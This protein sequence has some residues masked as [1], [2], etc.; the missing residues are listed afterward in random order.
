M[1]MSDP[2]PERV[3]YVLRIRLPRDRSFIFARAI[4]D[5]DGL[6]VNLRLIR[7]RYYSRRRL[8]FMRLGGV[9]PGE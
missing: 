8:E 6:T 2:T 3:T 4:R 1:S 9:T 7:R 5:D